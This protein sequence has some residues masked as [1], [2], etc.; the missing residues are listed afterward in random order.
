MLLFPHDMNCGDNVVTIN[1]KK[2]HLTGKKLKKI[3]GYP[4]LKTTPK[5]FKKETTPI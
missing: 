1:A 5:W 2:I 3:K 4:G